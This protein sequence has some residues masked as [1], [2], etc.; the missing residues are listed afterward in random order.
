MT[1]K[2]AS[3]HNSLEKNFIKHVIPEIF[4]TAI[5]IFTLMN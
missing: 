4:Q 1:L 3:G 5:M 2:Q